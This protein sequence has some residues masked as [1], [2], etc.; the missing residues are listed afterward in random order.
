MTAP[1][2]PGQMT[3]IVTLHQPT[4]IAD[5]YGQHAGFADVAQAAAKVEPL[6][7]REFF[8]AAAMQSPAS[9]RVSIYWRGDV[10]ASWRLTWLGTVYEVITAPIDVDARHE[11]LELMC[12]EVAK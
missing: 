9:L 5:A 4:T 10:R 7:G 3:E 11:H 12:Q 1:L 8:A 6:W 2:Y